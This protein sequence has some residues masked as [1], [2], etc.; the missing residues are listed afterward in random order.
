ML[1]LAASFGA[2]VIAIGLVAFSPGP[3]WKIRSLIGPTGTEL[4][5]PTSWNAGGTAILTEGPGFFQVLRPDGATIWRD[6]RGRAPAWV[7]DQTIL[8]LDPIDPMTSRIRRIDLE[9]GQRPVIGE[10]LRVGRLVGDG[11]GH[12]AWRTAIGDRESIVLDPADGHEI[13]RL[14]DLRAHLWVADGMLLLKDLARDF[15][16]DHPAA[17]SLFVWDGDQKVRPIG[18]GLIE[19]FDFL[20]PSPGGDAIACICASTADASASLDPGIY[21]VPLDGSAATMLMPWDQPIATSYPVVAW[22]DETSLAV[23]DRSGLTRVST[24]GDRRALLGSDEEPTLTGDL[25]GPYRL[26]DVVVV[27]MNDP[28][29]PDLVGQLVVID[30]QQRIIVRQEFPAYNR[31]YLVVDRARDRAILVTDPFLPDEPLKL[32]VLEYR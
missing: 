19:L 7:D 22:L 6:G 31:P 23:I 10:V 26:Q 24:N 12:M 2:A 17:G 13:A 28:K 14:P 16:T 3:T 20:V 18:S 25:G 32:F 21:R 8:V 27:S 9:S 29:D 11:V 15:T 1:I 4:Y 30:D 5:H